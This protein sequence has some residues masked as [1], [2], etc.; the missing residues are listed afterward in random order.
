MLRKIAVLLVSFL[1]FGLLA[2]PSAFADP[3]LIVFK[4]NAPLEVPGMVIEP[5]TYSVMN[6]TPNDNSGV[7]AI[8]NA[9]GQTVGQ[10]M[11]EPITRENAVGHTVLDLQ[12]EAHSPDRIDYFIPSGSE[13]GYKLL[14]PTAALNPIGSAMAVNGKI[15]GR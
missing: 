5:G 12:K 2:T 4:T 1:A 9:R 11:A 15:N 6:M 13:Q 3:E 7:L 14:Y 10:F 8:E